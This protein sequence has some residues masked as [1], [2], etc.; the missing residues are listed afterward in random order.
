MTAHKVV[1]AEMQ[2]HG[3]LVFSFGL[4]TA[5]PYQY[6]RWLSQHMIA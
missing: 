4:L 3:S 1:N 2:R 6:T 5:T